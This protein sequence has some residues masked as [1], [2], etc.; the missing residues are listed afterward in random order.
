MSDS[1]VYAP[2]NQCD[3]VGYEKASDL[4]MSMGLYC[5]GDCFGNTRFFIPNVIGM[6]IDQSGTIAHLYTN[7]PYRRKGYAKQLLAIVR[8]SGIKVYHSDNCTN[9]GM[10]F[11]QSVK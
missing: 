5:A 7:P 1:R 8:H 9:D 11:K 3:L 6:I 4:L 10:A 2:I